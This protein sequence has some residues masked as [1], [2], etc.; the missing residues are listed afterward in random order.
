[1]RTALTSLDGGQQD[2][3]SILFTAH[4]I[5]ESMA[6]KYPYVDQFQASARLVVERLGSRHPYATVYQSRSGRPEDPWLGPDICDVLRGMGGSD[7]H[8][9]VVS[10]LGF[11]C[12]HVEVL[13]DLDV[14]AAAVARERGVPF[15]RAL[16]V[17]DHPQ[18]LDAIADAVLTVCRR[19]ARARPLELVSAP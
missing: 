10:P 18:F 13:Y 17:N 19:Y 14:E 9:V 1:V 5:P 3:A 6:A 15:V 8:P 16:A 11:I 12:D 4:S 7:P 2:R